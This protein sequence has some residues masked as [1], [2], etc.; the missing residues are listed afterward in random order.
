[1]LRQTGIFNLNLYPIPY[2]PSA[3]RKG[4]LIVIF[5]RLKDLQKVFGV[6]RERQT[7]RDTDRQTETQT[8]TQRYTETDRQTDRQTETGQK[9]IQILRKMV[10][11][12]V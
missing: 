6:F 5:S 2:V 1:M 4:K 7:D 9:E 8:E 3:I 11:R 12:T 10:T